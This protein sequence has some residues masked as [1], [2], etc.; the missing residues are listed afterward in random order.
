MK[1]VFSSE[2]VSTSNYL[3]STI[4]LHA[5]TYR[6]LPQGTAFQQLV[7]ELNRIF[8]KTNVLKTRTVGGY[9]QILFYKEVF[10]SKKFNTCPQ[11]FRAK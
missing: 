3:F 7:A 10:M 9:Q 5:P 11:K 2:R 4:V 8:F 1:N 6:A